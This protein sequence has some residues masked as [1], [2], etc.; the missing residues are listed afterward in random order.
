MS[1]LKKTS[2]LRSSAV[3][4]FMTL[5]SRVL[6]LVRD[7]VLAHLLGAGLAADMYYFAQKIPNFFRRLFAEG[8]FSQAF[9]PVLSEYTN[10]RELKEVKGL[11]DHVAGT[12]G[13][14]LLGVTLLGVVGS[15]LLVT[16][17]GTGFLGNDEKFT[18]ASLLLKITFPYLLFISLTAFA[19]SV[20]NTFGR[21]AVPA[22]TPVWL[23]V[24]IIGAAWL[25][26]PGM[27][28]PAVALAWG[29][30]FGGVIQLLFQLPSLWRIDLLPRPRWGWKT[31][32]VQRIFRL[33]LPALFGVSVTQ[34]NLLF[35]TFMASFLKTGSITWLYLSDRLIQF[36]LGVFG[37]AIAT[38][39]LP[40]LSHKHATRS[41][42]KFGLTLDWGIRMVVLVGLPSALGLFCLVEPVLTV[43]FYG[44]RFEVVDIQMAGQ[45]LTA[46][47]FGLL[48]FM[49]IKVLA[50]GFY[51]RQDTKTPVKI[52]M[53]AMVTNI[54]LNLIL[55]F[56]LAHAGLA[57]AT[58]L[59]ATL[60]AGLL[61]YFLKKQQVYLP[62]P[63]WP[64][65]WAQ[66]LSANGA[67]LA[68]LIV[69]NPDL[70][71]W[72]AQGRWAGLGRLTFLIGLGAM[73]YGAVL[74]LCGL[75][76]HHFRSEAKAG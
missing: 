65:F 10:Q 38:A 5:V 1:K 15:P 30:F 8:S 3:V 39:I 18:L 56:P 66:L 12:L 49:L 29:I 41:V 64:K 52:A 43:L 63:G 2:L 54:V 11:V 36:P 73:L 32:G 53:V 19:G 33:M 67:M 76:P 46:Y 26:A 61:F 74:L 57:L 9:L 13:G 42:E 4:G 20:L 45:S 69:F 40:N 58:T 44:N 50:P 37:I 55:V 17:F 7:I 59:S 23:N 68:F 34:I 22:L 24:S 60:N 48:S 31:E 51:S 35:D 14:I 16:L 47:C 72:I 62:R 27:E 6:G 70:S 71:F 75:R 28:Q 25:F 21:F